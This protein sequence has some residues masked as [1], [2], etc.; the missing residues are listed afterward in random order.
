ME[1]TPGPQINSQTELHTDSNGEKLPLCVDLD[2]TLVQSDTLVE[3]LVE[4]IRQWRVLARLPYWLLLGKARLKRELA[5]R[6]RLDY[7]FLPYRNELLTYLRKEK[8]RGRYLVLATAANQSIAD[9][10]A[11]HLG[12]FDEVLASNDTIN[13]RGEAKARALCARFG[14]RQ[15]SYAGNA[16]SDLRVW[17]SAGSAVL[18]ATSR[19][20]SYSALQATNLEHKI[21]RSGSRLRAL[22]RALRPYQWSKNAL[23]FVPILTSGELR[24]LRGWYSAGLMFAALCMVASALYLVNDLTDLTADRRHPRK[25]NRPLASGAPKR[26]SQRHWC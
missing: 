22:L 23:V 4:L 16:H 18:V 17:R 8:S 15:F 14:E 5:E 10:V 21:G 9:G 20:I 1:P 24:D 25:R 26:E 6:A 13:L 3:S 2:G 11:A 12:I 7:A 19:S